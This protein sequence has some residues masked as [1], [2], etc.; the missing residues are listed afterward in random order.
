MGH[1]AIR[2]PAQSGQA[3][4]LVVL[5]HGYGADASDLMGLADDFKLTLPDT[6]FVGIEA[7]QVC[8]VWAA[9]RQWFPL[10]ERNPKEYRLGVETAAP[11]LEQALT[12]EINHAGVVSSQVALFGFSQGAMMALHVG[13]C[14]ER[15]WAGV[16]AYSG[17]LA[18]PCPLDPK[19]HK[20]PVLLVHG[21]EDDVVPFWNLSVAQSAL[22]NAEVPVVAQA[23]PDLG[24][25][26]S[27]R[28]IELARTFLMD[29]LGY[30]ADPFD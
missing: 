4:S 28:G 22:E 8:D 6:A 16:M 21:T 23:I 2:Q 13:L 14:G 30:V 19:G 1:E 26:I 25:G 27:V 7:P 18:S 20:P 5:L 9:G 12:A 17:A 3:R 24:H 11:F 29:V 15:K 10:S